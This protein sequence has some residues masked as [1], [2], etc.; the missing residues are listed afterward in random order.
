MER[1]KIQMN[2]E[3]KKLITETFVVFRNLGLLSKLPE[4]VKIILENNSDEDFEFEYNTKIPLYEYNLDEATSNMISYLYIK[5]ICSDKEK[6]EKLI[7][8]IKA[9][10]KKDIQTEKIHMKSDIIES[11]TDLVIEDV[12]LEPEKNN[13]VSNSNL[14]IQKLKEENILMKFINKIKS[15]FNK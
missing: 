7:N 8:K 2:L 14:Q 13:I 1:N 4:D 6:K 9:N 5:Y 10:E 12:E 3:D 11:N 15:F